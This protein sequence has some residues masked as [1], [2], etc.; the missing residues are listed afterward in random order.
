MRDD[1][2]DENGLWHWKGGRGG[3]EGLLVFFGADNH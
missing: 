3:G 2:V 1:V